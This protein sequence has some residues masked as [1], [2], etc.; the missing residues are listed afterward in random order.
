MFWIWM[1][2]TAVRA[3]SVVDSLALVDLFNATN[4]A[5]WTQSWNLQEPVANWYG[6]EI[7]NGRVAGLVLS[8]NGLEGAI[9]ASIAAMDALRALDLSYN[10][11][12]EIEALP[13]NLYY[14]DLSHNAFQGPIPAVSSELWYLNLSHNA[15]AGPIPELSAGTIVEIDLSHNNLSG[16][17]PAE[18]GTWTELVYLDFSHNNLSG[19]IPASYADIPI[20]TTMN[21]SH[22]QLSGALPQTFELSTFLETLR[23][24]NNLLEGLPTLASPPLSGA[25][26]VQNNRLDFGDLEPNY[27]KFANAAEYGYAPQDSVGTAQ[28]ITAWEGQT[29]TLSAATP[30]A[31]NLYRWYFNGAP[32]SDEPG[33]SPVF[34]TTATQSGTFDC[35]ISNPLFPELTLHRRPVRL[36][37][38]PGQ[39]PGDAN[40]DRICDTGDVF[41]IAAAYGVSGPA[42]TQP[43]VLWQAYVP[44]PDWHQTYVWRGNALNVKYCDADGDGTVTLFD[45]A[46]AIAN[47][48]LSY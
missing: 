32:L 35:E 28:E 13:P 3:Q 18:I 5:Q 26:T 22:N 19:T 23:L 9:P 25:F 36:S 24:E 46:V 40:R 31:N 30:G 1:C 6:V 41:A 20:L 15:F 48:G 33:S 29:I 21:L 38:V 43:G 34:E 47:R 37:V 2:L 4:G 11:L 39:Y 27:A 10:Q 42:R 16:E 44:A 7:E 8:Q 17:L 12:S 45:L 14:L